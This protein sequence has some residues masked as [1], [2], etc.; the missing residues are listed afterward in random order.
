MDFSAWFE[1]YLGGHWHTFGARYNR[2]RIG[3]SLIGR[4]RDAGDVPITTVFGQHLLE[5]FSVITEGI[6]PGLPAY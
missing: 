2:H 1:A 4:G 5:S 3:R 6:N